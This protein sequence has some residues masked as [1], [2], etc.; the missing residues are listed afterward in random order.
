M[1]GDAVRE[2]IDQIDAIPE[3]AEVDVLINSSGGDALTAWKLMSVLRERFKRVDVLVPYMAFSA[4]TIFAMGAD[5]IVMHPH[6]SLGPIDPQITV[7]MPD[8]SRQFAYEDL[9]A[10]LHFLSKEMKLTEQAH[11]SSV[12]DKLFTTVDP[13]VVGAARRASE[14]SAEVGARLL[15]MHMKDEQRC[16]QIAQNLNKTFFAH[17][18]AVS[19]SRASALELDVA[20]S[21]PKLEKLI[22]NAFLGLESVLELRRPFN[23]L[24][25]LLADPA[26]AQHLQQP[27]QVTPDA[28]VRLVVSVVES[29]RHATEFVRE[30]AL[31][32]VRMP[33]GNIQLRLTETSTGWREAT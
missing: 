12:V 30:A 23:P 7:R 27:G 5:Q 22:W 18:D 29:I 1:A 8:K 19:R 15:K 20:K 3:G 9:G 17:G 10:F 14:L 2:F 11:F 28:P 16:V 25:I 26:R 6:A 31:S 32:G 13:L 21:D 4:A 24:E 33:D